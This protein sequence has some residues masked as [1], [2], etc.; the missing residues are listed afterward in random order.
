MLGCSASEFGASDEDP[1][2]WSMV[3]VAHW[4]AHE[5]EWNQDEGHCFLM[6][7]A[8]SSGTVCQRQIQMCP[9]TRYNRT[10]G[11]VRMS[12]YLSL[13]EYYYVG[14]VCGQIVWSG[15]GR[16]PSEWRHQ[17]TA[18]H[19]G[20]VHKTGS[21]SHV[22][23]LGMFSKHSWRKDF[24]WPKLPAWPSNPDTWGIS[25][26]EAADTAQWTGTQ[27]FAIPRLITVATDL[28][29]RPLL[30]GSK[31]LWIFEFKF[32]EVWRWHF[33]IKSFGRLFDVWI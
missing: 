16:L 29:S 21:Q 18:S 15:W 10:G 30:G 1:L 32:Y 24:P 8:S 13:T 6:K 19:K 23:F 31:P 25:C 4:L 2:W 33:N 5:P 28:W 26:S 17:L 27:Q 3:M 9:C 14:W 11:T 7:S 22:W 20:L 12:T